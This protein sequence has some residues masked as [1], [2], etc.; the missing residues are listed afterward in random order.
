MLGEILKNLTFVL[1]SGDQ[2]LSLTLEY[3]R[4]CS[5]PWTVA[6]IG[7]KLMF[8]SVFRNAVPFLWAEFHVSMASDGGGIALLLGVAL[9]SHFYS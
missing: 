6:S 9:Y 1:C 8:F 2:E 3:T 4:I 7:I 5:A